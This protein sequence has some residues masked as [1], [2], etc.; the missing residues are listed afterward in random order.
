[1]RAARA[2]GGGVVA[3][4]VLEDPD[5]GL[6]V[7]EVNYT[8]EFRN[9]ILPTGVDIPDR[10]VDFALRVAEEGWA[11]AN[12][13]QN[14]A[15]RVSGRFAGRWRLND[16][17]HDQSRAIASPLSGAS[18]YVGGELLRL[19][20]QHPQVEVAQ[21]TSERNAGAYVHFTHPNLRGATKLQ[22]VSA[23]TWRPATCSSWG[24]PTVGPWTAS[25]TSPR[26]LNALST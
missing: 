20:L 2:V 1:M 10:M 17:T 8:M 9:S 4:D 5:R 19:L 12:G 24:C 26:G 11:A 25:S 15:P 6:L 14:G 3:I 23:A 13:W 7:N 22:F 21:V 18:G 16:E